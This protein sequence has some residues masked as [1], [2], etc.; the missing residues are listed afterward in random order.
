[1]NPKATKEIKER[2][3]GNADDEDQLDDDDTSDER[4]CSLRILGSSPTLSHQSSSPPSSDERQRSSHRRSYDEHDAECAPAASL[5]D[6]RPPETNAGTYTSTKVSDRDRPILWKG[7]SDNKP[8]GSATSSKRDA[9]T[10]VPDAKRRKQLR[11]ES[12]V[13]GRS[14][15]EYT[16]SS[17]P[18]WRTASSSRGSSGNPPFAPHDYGHESRRN[19]WRTKKD[20]ESRNDR[21]NEGSTPRK[22]EHYEKGRHVPK[23]NYWETEKRSSPLGPTSSYT[24]EDKWY[25]K[26]L[27]IWDFNK[28]PSIKCLADIAGFA[29]VDETVHWRT[30]GEN[31]LNLVAKGVID[32]C[33]KDTWERIIVYDPRTYLGVGKNFRPIWV[34]EEEDRSRWGLAGD[35]PCPLENGRVRINLS[36]GSQRHC[37][38][39]P[40]RE[41]TASSSQSRDDDRSPYKPKPT[42]SPKYREDIKE[43]IARA[44]W[45][46][47]PWEQN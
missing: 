33:H 7:R 37:E 39:C 13:M 35:F 8:D 12:P 34:D 20:E 26:N 38:V 44:P 47:R 31:K 14:F 28:M 36:V 32:R 22:H 9:V 46:S 41:F 4:R 30:V 24:H 29:Q 23:Y 40:K 5:S 10:N 11:D 16:E 45:N 15:R 17:R 19:E 42:K 6:E 21:W 27:S 43:K 18:G 25:S 1:M 2:L 3:F